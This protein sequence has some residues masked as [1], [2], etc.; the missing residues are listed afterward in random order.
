MLKFK[1]IILNHHL[2][3]KEKI[4]RSLGLWGRSDS[5]KVLFVKKGLQGDFSPLNSSL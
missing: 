2:I 5:K 1:K 4:E 3:K